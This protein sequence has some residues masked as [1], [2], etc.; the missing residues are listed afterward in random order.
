[1][2]YFEG[3]QK[4]LLRLLRMN[5][6]QRLFTCACKKQTHHVLYDL[7][8]ELIPAEVRFICGGTIYVSGGIKYD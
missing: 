6:D 2:T 4:T 3:T 8:L 1:M 7:D 5:Y